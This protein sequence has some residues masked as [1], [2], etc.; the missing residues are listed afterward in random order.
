MRFLTR[1]DCARWCEEHG[2]PVDGQYPKRPIRDGSLIDFDIPVDAGKRVALCRLLWKIA[3]G[4]S[5]EERLLWI[6]D[7]SIWPS[8]EHLPL[9]TR[10]R[11]ALGETRSLR[12]APGCLC[13]LHDDEDGLTVLVVSCLFL[14]DCWLFNKTGATI[15]LS[16]DEF[17]NV[18]RPSTALSFDTVSELGRLG[19]IRT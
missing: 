3:G 17:G 10:L 13:S 14:W 19:V 5:E 2:F 6:E 4:Q 9:W 18:F 8:G 7:W 11:E 16:H 12:E 1:S 15:F